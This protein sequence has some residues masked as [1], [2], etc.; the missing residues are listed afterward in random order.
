MPSSRFGLRML[1]AGLLL[2]ATGTLSASA[3]EPAV[4]RYVVGMSGMT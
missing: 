2:A 1:R 3:R 4:H